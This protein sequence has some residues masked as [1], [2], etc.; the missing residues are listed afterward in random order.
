MQLAPLPLDEVKRIDAV[1]CTNLLDSEPEERF[2]RITRLAHHLFDIP[3]VFI[4]LVDKKRVWFKSHY[5]SDANEEPRDISFC[6]HT[7]CNTVTDDKSSRLF[8]VTDAKSDTK[9]CDNPF[10]TGINGLRYYMGFILQSAENYNIGTLCMVDLRPRTFSE[11]DK[12][13]FSDLGLMVEAEL[14]NNYFSAQAGVSNFLSHMSNESNP[15]ALANQ[16]LNFSDKLN[17]TL[18]VLN[19]LLQKNGINYKEWRILN[20]IAQREFTSPQIVSQKLAMSAPLV[21]RYLESLELQ[22]LIDRKTPKE[23][24]RRYV[25]IECTDLGKE[26]WLKGIKSTYHLGSLYLDEMLSPN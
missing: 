20:E 7:I 3:L 2:D 16:F 9:F 18:S 11:L 26:I 21:S 6:G 1:Y 10:V 4:A 12:N 17:S 19:E 8:E 5:G 15:K 24:D 23:G 22:G 13:L 25:H 14:N